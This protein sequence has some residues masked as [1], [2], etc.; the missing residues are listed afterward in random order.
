MLDR[1][2]FDVNQRSDRNGYKMAVDSIR[3][4]KKAP[5]Q[6]DS[7]PLPHK[8]QSKNRI[9]LLPVIRHGVNLKKAKIERRIRASCQTF[10]WPRTKWRTAK[11]QSILL[12]LDTLRDTLPLDSLT[13]TPRKCAST[14]VQASN[15]QRIL[16]DRRFLF[17]I[18]KL[19]AH[20][21][22]RWDLRFAK[23]LRAIRTR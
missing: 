2:P 18:E 3:Y 12:T 7:F 22:H 11:K 1:R 21:G 8:R 20:G 19:T 4:S 17:I 10:V 15:N 16:N 5:L 13:T 23:F 14:V 9:S 6:R